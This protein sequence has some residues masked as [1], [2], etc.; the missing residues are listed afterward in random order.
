MKKKLTVKKIEKPKLTTDG[1]AMKVMLRIKPEDAKH[2]T[3]IKETYNKKQMTDAIQIAV[4]SAP[5]YIQEI[6]SLKSE[7]YH[8]KMLFQKL[9]STMQQKINAEKAVSDAIKFVNENEK[10]DPKKHVKQVTMMDEDDFD[11][12]D[13]EDY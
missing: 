3:K 11:T 5:G 6:S 2:Y 4:V 12:D 10:Y 9:R 13:D 8:Q 1:F 7:L